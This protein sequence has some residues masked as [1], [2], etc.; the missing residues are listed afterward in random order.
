MDLNYEKIDQYSPT[1]TAP[2]SRVCVS[3]RAIIVVE[4]KIL[5]SH[6]S[7]TG[8]YMSPGGS[9]E[10]G[11]TLEECCIR[12]LMEETGFKVK[13]IKQF[14]TVNEYCYDTLYVSNYFICDIVGECERSLT[15]TETAK[16]MVPKW[17]ELENAVELFSEYSKHT[18]DK[19]SLYRREY[20]VVNKYICSKGC[21][22]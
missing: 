5:L 9:L 21:E 1:Y 18:P 22:N 19:E 8:F 10:E 12:E 7:N 6:E 2:Y 13:P 4:N 3:S 11:E 15:E 16:G 14:V 17:V 20:T